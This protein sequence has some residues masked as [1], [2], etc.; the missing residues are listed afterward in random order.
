MS[1][2]DKTIKI[3]A[4]SPEAP[5]DLAPAKAAEEK[6]LAEELAKKTAQVDEE[7]ARSLAHLN[8][9][10]QLRDSL[11]QE[12]TR[13]TEAA[14]RIAD[15]E[16]KQNKLMDSSKKLVDRQE[17]KLEEL[18]GKLAEQQT[19][20][21]GQQAAI[22]SQQA[23]IDEQQAKF[24]VLEAQASGNGSKVAELQAHIAEQDN[25]LTAQVARIRSLI[26]ALE[27]VSSIATAA[28]QNS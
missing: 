21:T 12:Q 1:T 17:A 3:R 2:G 23:A 7:K 22:A 9:I 13:S 26:D 27:K 11:K 20:I 4:F 10:E 18:Q 14:K 28:T 25:K 6:R 16:E 24:A 19:T 5:Q 15:L 8:T